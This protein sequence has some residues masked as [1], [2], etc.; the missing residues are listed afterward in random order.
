MGEL[1]GFSLVNSKASPAK[2]AMHDL[3]RKIILDI[4]I[5]KSVLAAAQNDEPYRVATRFGSKRVKPWFMARKD[6][7]YVQCRYGPAPLLLNGDADA[8]F[9]P[10]LDDV[11]RVL[12]AL[13]AAVASGELDE[14]IRQTKAKFNKQAA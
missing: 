3:R 8:I 9:V 4:E 6:G 12:D 13:H 14:A 7:W 11:A 10:R 2:D 1:S 5:Q